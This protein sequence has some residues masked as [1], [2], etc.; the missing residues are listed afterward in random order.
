MDIHY[1]MDNLAQRFPF[2]LID[3]IVEQTDTTITAKKNVTISELP[4]IGHFPT[5]PIYPGVLLIE[6]MTQASS[7]LM[8]KTTP[9]DLLAE[10]EKV[11]FY[12][13][14]KPGNTLLIES[15]LVEKVLGYYK[16]TCLI[17]CDGK[18]VAAGKVT[19]FGSEE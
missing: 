18:K 2:L 3:E 13:P 17:T 4:F 14:V 5:H 9:E 15:R 19:L 12:T 8:K 1:V 6:S 10:V 16:F 11:K 7:L